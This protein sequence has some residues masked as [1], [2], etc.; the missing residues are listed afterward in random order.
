MEQQELSFT[1]GGNATIKGTL[2]VSYKTKHTLTIRFSNPVAYYLPKGV[3]RVFI[4]ALFINAK[5][6]N[7]PRCCPLVGE[8][9]KWYNQTVNII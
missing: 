8:W 7:Q 6:C 2:E 3:D 5:I 4:A 1:A 9:I